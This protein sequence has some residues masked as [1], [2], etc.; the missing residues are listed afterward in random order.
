MLPILERYSPNTSPSEDDRLDQ[1]Q[2]SQRILIRGCR[3]VAFP[4]NVHPSRAPVIRSAEVSEA[5][6]LLV[7]TDAGIGAILRDDKPVRAKRLARVA[8][9]HV[10]LDEDLVIGARVD[11]LVQVVLVEVAVDVLVAE[12]ARRP[13]RPHVPPVVVVVRDV[14]VALVDRAQTVAVAYQGGFP[15]VVEVVP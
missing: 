14:Q 8:A 6:D 11:R 9:E 10:A 7:T 15:V 2:R 3:K 12:A 1:R 5:V 13:P 4:R